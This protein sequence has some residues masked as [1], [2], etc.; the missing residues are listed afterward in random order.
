MCHPKGPLLQKKK[1]HNEKSGKNSESQNQLFRI[2]E[3]KRKKAAIRG[4]LHQEK[5]PESQ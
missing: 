2:L 1:K 4:M 3:I 5:A